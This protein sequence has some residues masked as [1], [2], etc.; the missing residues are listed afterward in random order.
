M[1]AHEWQVA[2]TV[3][4]SR[5]TLSLDQVLEIH[6]A[7]A[8]RS[9]ETS[10]DPGFKR[11]F[12]GRLAAMAQAAR[13]ERTPIVGVCGTVNSGKSTVVA[14]FL[15]EEGQRRVLVGQL[16]KEGTHRFVFW[17]P[18]AWRDNGLGALVEE[19]IL[20]QTDLMPELLAETPAEAAAQYNAAVNRAQM[21][22]IPLMAYDS[23]LD[24]G[25]IGFLDCPDIQRSL[26]NSVDEPT[27]HL[28]LER[29]VTIAPLCS[30]FVLVSSM[31][32]L[33]AEDVGK[34]FHA[35]GH[36]ASQAPLYFVLNMTNG[37]DAETY[38]PEAQ[39]V[40]ERWRRT[41]CVKRI[42][43][44]P[45]EH[46]EDPRIPARPSITS[47]DGDRVALCEL[48]GEL[49]SAELQKSHYASCV[50]SLKGLLQNV[51]HWVTE[52]SKSKTEQVQA[53]AIGSASFSQASL[54]MIKGN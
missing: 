23:A 47:M 7:E 3:Y 45:F 44:A 49:D 42:Y 37:N 50:A 31:Q 52:T 1:K 17:L 22:N 53:A 20:Q 48:A 39:R 21:F 27:A 51:R 6:D 18:E 2:E 5:A 4:P 35:L 41:E 33:G 16:E 8:G 9:D 34:V 24:S 26:D 15:S 11:A 25:G 32:Q 46:R 14:G 13:L 19:M 28:R 43:L 10:P 40:I 54:W 30:A 29:L 12:Q 38:R 36:A